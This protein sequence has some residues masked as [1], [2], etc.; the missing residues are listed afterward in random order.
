MIA[1]LH[2]VYGCASRGPGPP[3]APRSSRPGPG[4]GINPLETGS[5]TSALGTAAKAALRK[6]MLRTFG[7][8]MSTMGPFLTGAAVR[9]PQP[10][11]T[12]AWP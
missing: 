5:I 1:E 4:S 10:L 12:K 8:S 6:R 3:A 9:R 7:R 2:E 11:A